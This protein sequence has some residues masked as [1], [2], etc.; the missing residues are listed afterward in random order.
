MYVGVSSCRQLVS[1]GIGCQNAAV[2]LETIRFYCRDIN[3]H[4][5]LFWGIFVDHSY[6]EIRN[7]TIEILSGRERGEYEP[8]QYVHLRK[9]VNFVFKRREGNANSAMS[10]LSHNDRELFLEIFWD[11]FRQGIITL[12]M[13]DSSP[14]FPFFRVSL[15]GR[16]ILEHQ[17]AYFF[18]DISTYEG[19]IRE[20]IPD[21]NDITLV[22]LKEAMQDFLSGCVLSSSV[23]LGVATEHSF[24]LMLESL[25]QNQHYQPIFQNVFNERTILK[26]INKFKNILTHIQGDLSSDIK[27]DLDTNLMGI[28]AI[29]RNFRNESGHPTGKI[30]NREQCYILLNLFIPYCKKVYQLKDFFSNP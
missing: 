27:E 22:Y 12:G 21:I 3:P 5:K 24:Y 17:E 10:D 2:L 26:K 6:E 25:E 15:M 16:L 30:I 9:N 20:N 23:M 13:S 18:H 1:D 8:N 14:Q 4:Y 19:I 7:V 29:I 11:L 28:I